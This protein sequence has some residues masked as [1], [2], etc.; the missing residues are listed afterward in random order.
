MKKALKI[1]GIIVLLILVVGFFF[2]NTNDFEKTKVIEASPEQ[3]FVLVNDLKNWPSWS[4]W[5]RSEPDMEIIYGDITAGEGAKYE[6]HGDEMGDGN[7][8]IS[9]SVVNKSV[10]TNIDFGASSPTKGIFTFEKVEEGTKVT[11]RFINENGWNPINRLIGG[12]FIA[13]MVADSY[14]EGLEFLN[15]VAVEAAKE[16][17]KYTIS[18]EEVESAGVHYL[19]IRVPMPTSTEEFG[20]KM[21]QLYG[22]IGGFMAQNKVAMAGM[23]LNVYYENEDGSMDMECGLP[24]AGLVETP[25]GRVV[26]KTTHVGTLLKGIHLGDYPELAGSH[27]QMMSYLAAYDYEQVGEMYEIYIT[28]PA[29]E[30]D[31]AKWE[32]DIYIPVKKKG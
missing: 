25:D 32:T 10:V 3:V 2:P 16:A 26:A 1:L 28:D 5:I 23:P 27:V 29:S 9:E 30:P 4:P 14:V 24:I 22:E 6:W 19:G 18:I 12:V 11:W 15:E 8:W 20:P 7:L 17:A 31:T 13:P 21:G